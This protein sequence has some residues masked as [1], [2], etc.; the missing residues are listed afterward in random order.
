MDLGLEDKVV[1]VTGGS[2]GIGKAI[3]LGLSREGCRVAICARGQDL[4]EK[5][6]AGIQRETGNEI[7]CS[8]ADLTQSGDVKRMV[9]TIVAHFGRIDVLVNNAGS[10]P[11]GVL[12]NLTEKGKKCL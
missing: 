11:G 9:E 5:V 2:K 10:S 8:T 3:A 7:F 6:A 4:L 12:E 1:L